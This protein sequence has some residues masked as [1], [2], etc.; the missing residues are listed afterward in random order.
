MDWQLI[1]LLALILMIVFIIATTFIFYIQH[2]DKRRR[3]TGIQT[4]SY[5]GLFFKRYI[6]ESLQLKLQ[7]NILEH[8]PQK[9][10]GR[11]LF[12]ALVFTVLTLLSVLIG[13]AIY[14]NKDH[15]KSRIELNEHESNALIIR[16]Y[17]WNKHDPQILPTLGNNLESL[18]KTGLVLLSSQGTKQWE[19]DGQ[20][21]PKIA[22][23]Q[24]KSFA[25]K[26]GLKTRDCTWKQLKRCTKRYKNWLFVILPS[27]WDGLKLESLL[28]DDHNVLLYGAPLQVYDNDVGRFQWNDLQFKFNALT[29]SPFLSLVADRELTLNFDAGLILDVLPAFPNVI[30]H[31]DRPQGITVDNGKAAGGNS[32]TRLFAR[33][34]KNNKGRL[35]WMDFSPNPIDHA[36]ELNQRH[37]DGLMA[38][39]FRY[40]TREEYGHWGMWPADKPYAV[41]IEEDTE[42]K[43]ENAALVS[44]FF[45]K[46]NYPITWYALS[47][48]AQHHRDITQALSGSGEV[49]CHGDNHQPFTLN[50]SA[51]QHRR[52][53]T[54]R[55]VIEALTGQT[56]RT[57]RPPEEKYNSSTL[58]AIFNNHMTHF[59]AEN[60]GDRFTPVFYLTKEEKHQLISLPRMNSDDFNLWHDFRLRKKASI[61]LLTRE[62]E[63]IQKVGGLFLF[64]FHTQFMA[65]ESNFST[66]KEIAHHSAAN[67]AFFTTSSQLADWWQLRYQLTHNKPFNHQH[68]KDFQPSYLR[69]GRTG[70]ITRKIMTQPSDMKHSLAH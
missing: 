24:W 17:Q 52:I 36:D 26:H 18:R 20:K 55:K 56:V 12:F 53:A 32:H 40:F 69:V 33:V 49:A 22:E 13:S 44:N 8:A 39:I 6:P 42:D 19:V 35:V 28:L 67:N 62:A 16:D 23:Y 47:N 58:S 43:Y 2:W 21:I 27:V 31:S 50:D 29:S 5:A 1:S 4:E 63:W 34:G 9:Q 45:K 3:N 48:D 61:D 68:F 51:T 70:K 11:H 14:F 7:G 65:K 15:F 60:T 64:S 25:K 66:V 30:T 46:H 38:S 59:I 54:C 41:I 37:F 57:F 10:Q